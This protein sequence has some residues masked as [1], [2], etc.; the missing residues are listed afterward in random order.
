ME[1]EPAREATSASPNGLCAAGRPAGPRWLSGAGLVVPNMV[2]AGVLLGTGFM[3]QELG[4]GS[5]MGAWLLTLDLARFGH[6]GRE[7]MLLRAARRAQS[8]PAHQS[9]VEAELL[10]DGELV[11]A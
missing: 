4:P 10:L 2:G 9:A 8:V 1:R 6:L 11:H 7:F 5:T 3:T